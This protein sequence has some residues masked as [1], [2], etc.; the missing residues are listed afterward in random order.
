MNTTEEIKKIQNTLPNY[1]WDII[2]DYA[3]KYEVEQSSIKDLIFKGKLSL[4]DSLIE[5]YPNKPSIVLNSLLNI[6]TAIRRE[7]RNIENITDDDYK[8]IFQELK[9]ENIGKEAIEDIMRLKADSPNL[10]IQQSIEKLHIET[11]SFEDL[12]IIISE[13]V[14]KNSKII[15]ERGMRSMGPLMGEVMEKVRGKID[16]EIVSK[17][18][19]EQILKKI[20][21]MK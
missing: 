2:E 3:K 6:A 1:P 17:E 14:N 8:K 10:S 19:K 7:G 18:L 16:G 13:I 11:L 20:K 9:N 5:I 21:E 12:K 15:K 4:F